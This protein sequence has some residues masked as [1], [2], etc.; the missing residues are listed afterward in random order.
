[1]GKGLVFGGVLAGLIACSTADPY[2][3]LPQVPPSSQDQSAST[4]GC[5]ADAGKPVEGTD[6]TKL[7][8][9]TGTKGTKGRCVPGTSLGNF[10]GKFEQASCTG[11]EECVPD[12]VVKEGAKIELKKCT[13]VLNSE[14][15]CF[16]PLAKD[17]VQ[18]YD[19]LKGAS[20]DCDD[21][22]VCAPCV[23]PLNHTET[24][25]CSTGSAAA[26]GGSDVKKSAPSSGPGAAGGTCP[27]VDPIL[28]ASTFPAEDCGSN[29][30]CV[31]ASLIPGGQGNSLKSCSKGKCAPKK[32][33]ERG[34]NYVPPTCR[35]IANAEGRCL[36]VGI[37]DIAKQASLLPGQ[38]CDSDERCAPCFDPRTGE[39][40]PACSTAPCDAPKEPKKVLAKCC[41]G[42]G[43]CVPTTSVDAKAAGMLAQD[44]CSG[45]TPLC[46]PIELAGGGSPA[47]SCTAALGLVTGICLPKCTLDTLFADIVQGTCN[48]DEMCAPCSFLPAGTC[49]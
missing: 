11:D 41:A 26:C 38:G 2:G 5:S 19:L 40:T 42:R 29:M 37:P 17:I 13:G 34:G 33:V 46:A 16:W 7:K 18:N 27:Q 43:Q 3:D 35:S 24:G 28:D 12:E 14:G 23:N 44:S 48:D 45:D 4:A 49:K 15:R 22:M 20:K 30:L 47:K 1:M 10:N 31:D 9:C 32:S 25:I 21:G 36:N 8:E 6:P 39:A